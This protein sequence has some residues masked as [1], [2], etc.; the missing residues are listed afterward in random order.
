MGLMIWNAAVYG[1]SLVFLGV[2]VPKAAAITA[3]ATVC[4]VIGYGRRW[5]YRFG[6]GLMVLAALVFINVLPPA[7]SWMSS[8]SQMIGQLAAK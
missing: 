5:I 1:I 4:A 2:V 6:F 8:L 3:L 7:P